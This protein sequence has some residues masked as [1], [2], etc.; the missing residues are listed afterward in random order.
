MARVHTSTTNLDLAAYLELSGA[1]L[2]GV[3]RQNPKIATFIFSHRNIL[4]LV[5]DYHA[6]RRIRFSPK[7]Y[8]ESRYRLKHVSSKL[9][10]E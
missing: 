8:A 4:K 1:R 3:E 7:A 6:C 2:E 5:N 10:A 9:L